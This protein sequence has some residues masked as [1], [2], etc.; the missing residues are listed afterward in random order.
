MFLMLD[1]LL[2]VLLE[3]PLTGGKRRGKLLWLFGDDV[4]NGCLI[5]VFCFS[6]IFFPVFFVVV[7]LCFACCIPGMLVLPPVGAAMLAFVLENPGSIILRYVC[8]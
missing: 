1:V 4:G 2:E 8:N 7:A 3:V 5:F 6:V